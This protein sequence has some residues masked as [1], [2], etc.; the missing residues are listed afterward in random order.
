MSKVEWINHEKEM[1]IEDLEELLEM[2]DEWKDNDQKEYYIQDHHFWIPLIAGME[3]FRK[4]APYGLYGE[5]IL[6]PSKHYGNVYIV[7][8]S[9]KDMYNIV[10]SSLN[11]LKGDKISDETIKEIY[12]DPDWC[13]LSLPLI[14]DTYSLSFFDPPN[15]DEEDY[16]V[17]FIT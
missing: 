9:A 15:E 14:C 1:M 10:K 4:L 8:G 3:V 13:T 11:N 6:E 2:M 12:G 17:K 7:K 5:P 16:R